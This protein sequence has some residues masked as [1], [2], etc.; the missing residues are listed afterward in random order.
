MITLKYI[1]N[2]HDSINTDIS[3]LETAPT[4]VNLPKGHQAIFY[5]KEN[6]DGN[7]VVLSAHDGEKMFRLADTNLKWVRSMRVLTNVCIVSGN[8][9][10]AAAL[11]DAINGS[12]WLKKDYEQAKGRTKWFNEAKFG[13]FVHWGVYSVAGGEWG[14]HKAGYAEH[15]QRVAKINQ[16]DYLEHFVKQFN[17]IYFDAEQWITT[18]KEAGMK[19]FVITAK[20]HD[21]FAIYHSDAYPYDMRLTPFKRDPIAELRDACERHGIKFGLYYSHA[22]DWGH[23]DGPGNDW[24]FTNGGGDDRLF[25]GELGLWFDQHPE[26][27]P[28]TAKYY[29]DTKSIPQIL[30]LI[31]KYKPDLLWFDTSHKLPPSE[32]LR[33]LRAIREADPNIVVNGRLA[34]NKKFGQGGDYMNTGDRAAETFPTPGLW[35]TIPT[36]NNS[37]GYSKHDKSHKLPEHFIKLLVKSAARGGNVLMNLGPNGQ[38]AI[39]QVDLDIISEIGKW[40][41]VN[42]ESVYGASRTPLYPQSFGETT[43]KDG[44]LYLHIFR[45]YD[46]K[47]TLGGLLNH[48]TKVYM[49]TD[50]SKTPLLVKR[51][52]RWDVEIALPDSLESSCVTVAVAEYADELFPGGG[53]FI[54]SQQPEH[55]HVFD[56]TYISPELA[57]G[58]GKPGNDRI[59]GF[60]GAEQS[61]IWKVRTNKKTAYKLEVVY[62]TAK[63]DVAGE[64]SIYTSGIKQTKAIIAADKLQDEVCDEFYIEVDGER[65]VVF[66]PHR[67]DGEFL[68]LF[69]LRLIPLDKAFVEDIF[70]DVD[71]TDLG[72]K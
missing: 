19:Y 25:E 50:K 39:E 17:P 6:F 30:E 13:C 7:S 3:L 43:L 1:N 29:V 44:K 66:R 52:N 62:T 48:P 34:P 21:G 45:Q 57:H 58:D 59:F 54:S 55:L 71:V 38:G 65:D 15:M 31:E 9:R 20:H 26:L 49:L 32:N 61:I 10:D 40:I 18:I 36:T 35:E 64:Y 22:F 42:G 12:G 28:R 47:I 8:E 46:N 56:A 60:T 72:D 23:P 67:I 63:P 70:V 2:K 27:V 4:E 24:E 33:I 51:I 41:K 16:A 69:G 53:R 37:Y 11:E 5:E 68:H 14:G